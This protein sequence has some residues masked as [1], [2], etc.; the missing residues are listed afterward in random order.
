MAEEKKDTATEEKKQEATKAAEKETPKTE[1]KKAAKPKTTA[2][3]KS[4]KAE[5]P[6]AKPQNEK[7]A[8]AAGKAAAN[9]AKAAEKT[10]APAEENGND[11]GT[12]EVLKGKAREYTSEALQ[13][14]VF[15]VRQVDAIKD[16][17]KAKLT[18]S[19][20]DSMAKWLARWGQYALFLAMAAG[21]LIG[22][23]LTFRVGVDWLFY[24][25]GWV[26]IMLVAQYI[27]VKFL[28]SGK[29]LIKSSP[30]KLSSQAFLDS[31]AVICLLG[32]AVALVVYVIQGIANGDMNAV[33]TGVGAFALLE[34]LAIIAMHPAMINITLE[35]DA[36]A[37]EE[38]I[39]VVGFFIKAFVKM[40]PIFFG[41]GAII[42]AVDLCLNFIYTCGANS[43]VMKALVALPTSAKYIL[44]AASIP[45]VTYLVF[46][47][48][49]LA[50]DVV[51]ALLSLQDKGGKK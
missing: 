45:L 35:S 43:G 50:I 36:N 28:D 38:A 31:V 19:V 9:T 41:V 29:I 14:P 26:F 42:G 18:D 25:L 37:G 13:D 49:Y 10:A 6:A 3:P 27:A 46:I 24:G 17:A 15:V 44:Y 34:F 1:E 12:G 51:R 39:G 5:K 20:F 4:E 2:K 16:L 8:P 7:A 23:V 33:W 30:S 11:K 21:L 22:L 47:T 48:T 32:G 40:A